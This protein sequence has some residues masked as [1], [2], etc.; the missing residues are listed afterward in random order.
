MKNGYGGIEGNFDVLR[1]FVFHLVKEEHLDCDTQNVVTA[2]E[3]SDGN[4]LD[5]QFLKPLCRL[6]ESEILGLGSNVC[7]NKASR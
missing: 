6:T 7:F 5:M 2:P 1:S 3:A 4:L